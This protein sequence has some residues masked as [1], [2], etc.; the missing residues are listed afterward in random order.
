MPIEVN[1]IY[2]DYL[3]EVIVQINAGQ[4][5]LLHPPLSDH[6]ALYGV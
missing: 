5:D 4:A 2:A 1:G 6:H 3:M